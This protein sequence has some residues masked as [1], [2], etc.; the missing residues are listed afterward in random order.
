MRAKQMFKK[1][2]YES[3]YDYLS[4]F[5]CE[6]ISYKK[7]KTFDFVTTPYEFTLNVIK[8]EQSIEITKKELKAIF[9]QLNELGLLSHFKKVDKAYTKIQRILDY[10][11]HY[12]QLP[13][14]FD[15]DLR[16]VLNELKG[17]E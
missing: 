1:L 16:S 17:D 4:E 14:D 3:K 10:L 15:I 8:D 9:E 6:S 11:D 12:K 13:K 2:G 5:G 7:N